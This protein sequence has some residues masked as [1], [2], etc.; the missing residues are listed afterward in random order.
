MQ[1]ISST[2]ELRY[3]IELLEAEHKLKTQ[4]LKEQFFLT[5]ESLKPINVLR[6]TIKEITSS[7]YLV[8]DVPGTIMGLASGYISK[9]IVTGRSASIVRKLIGSLLQ[10]GV[11]NVVAKNSNMIKSVVMVILEHFMHK[12]EMNPDNYV[13]RGQ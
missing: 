2:E 3:A 9:K 7:Q 8:E 1:S 12:K 4:L 5:Y 11:T 6:R 13:R 10:F